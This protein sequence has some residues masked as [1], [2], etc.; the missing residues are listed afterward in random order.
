MITCAT[1]QRRNMPEVEGTAS[2]GKGRENPKVEAAVWRKC[3]VQE[4]DRSRKRDQGWCA[5]V[6]ARNRVDEISGFKFRGGLVMDGQGRPELRG[7]RDVC[8][9][10]RERKGT[11]EGKDVEVKRKRDDG[12]MKRL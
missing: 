7:E 6:F 10:G 12:G 11:R 8:W 4:E 9:K 2:A 3:Q 5:R 1:T